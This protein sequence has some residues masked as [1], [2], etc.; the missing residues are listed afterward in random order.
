M[1]TATGGIIGIGYE[2]HDL[3]SFLKHLQPWKIDVLVDVRLNP[4]SRK[5]GFSKK[6]LSLAMGEAGIQ[7]EHCRS[8]GNPKD[9]RDGFWTPGTVAADAAHERYRALLIGEEAST[10][11]TELAE[12]AQSNHV[13]LLCFESSELCCHRRLVLDAVNEELSLARA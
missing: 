10:A 12:L 7:Y 13:A 2:G 9:N 3:D 6:A 4:I 8:L 11:V 1:W 5:R